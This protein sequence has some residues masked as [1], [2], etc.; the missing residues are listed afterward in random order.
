MALRSGLTPSIAKQLHAYH[1]TNSPQESFDFVHMRNLAQGI[2]ADSWPGIMKEAYRALRPGGYVELGECGV[3]VF[4]VD[5]TMPNES[6]VQKYSELISECMTAMNRPPATLD[7]LVHR[8]EDSGFVDIHSFAFMQPLGPWPKD[9]NQKMAGQF[10]II[11]S[12]T[13][14]SRCQTYNPMF[15]PRPVLTSCTAF[16]AYGL[17]AFTRY[18]GM[19][20]EEAHDLCSRAAAAI[21]S[22]NIHV[23]NLL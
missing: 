21:K 20:A 12:E 15:E 7:T 10:M 19:S 22:R 6:P 14:N 9:N 5:N 13:G 2:Q 16:H 4:S 17:A 8:L 23:H 11:N 1:I 3:E 18:L